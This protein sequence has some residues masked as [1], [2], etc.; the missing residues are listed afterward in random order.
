MNSFPCTEPDIRIGLITA[1][2]LTVTFHGDYVSNNGSIVS[3][4]HSFSVGCENSSYSPSDNN[5]YF[6]LQ[7]TIGIDFHWQRRELQ[8]FAGGVEIINEDN[9]VTAINIIGVEKYLQS[10]VSSEMNAGSPFEFICAHAII[11]RSWVLNQIYRKKPYEGRCVDSDK[12][13]IKWYDHQMHEKFHVCADD[14]CQRYQGLG[15]VWNENAAKAVMATAGMVL[16]FGN[17]IA[18]ARFSKCCGG[19]T[20]RFSTCWQNVD[21]PYLPA[22]TDSP[23]SKDVPEKSETQ[24]EEWIES[25]P[26]TA[27]CSSTSNEILTAVLNSYDLETKDFYRW[28]ITLTA[29]ELAETVQM[30]SGLNL[31]RIKNIKALHRGSSGRIDRLEIEGEHKKIII[32]KE[33]E[34]RRV[35]SKTHLYSSAFIAE[36]LERDTND[37]PAKWRL[38]GAGWGHGV[39]LCQIGAA[40]MT[41]RGI[42]HEDILGHYFPNTEI[43]KIY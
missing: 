7:I 32:G 42:G 4:T 25:R 22:V 21:L 30:K 35:L 19:I 36:P 43:K 5:C 34:I 27:Y 40:V 3:G 9:G 11:S 15:R 17:E 39:G 10:V 24:W 38:R 20:E 14:H 28:D 1:S 29:E 37:I 31:G 8:R 13:I 2:K 41:S 18:D 33:L 6:S 16:T 23:D 26:D 12:E